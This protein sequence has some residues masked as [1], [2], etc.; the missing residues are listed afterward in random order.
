MENLKE[1]LENYSKKYI[2]LQRNIGDLQKD[3]LRLEG[4]VIYLQEKIKN[5]NKENLTN[6]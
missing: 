4:I 6:T 1:E 3:L 5:E 2:D